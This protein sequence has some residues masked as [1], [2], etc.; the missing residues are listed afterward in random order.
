MA[1]SPGSQVSSSPTLVSYPQNDRIIQD[2][3]ECIADLKSDFED[4]HQP[5]TDD[6]QQLQRFCAKLEYLLR[7]DMKDKYTILGK[8]KDYWD[9]ICDCLGSTKGINDGIKYVKTLGDYKT[10][11]GKGRAFLRFC[12]MHNRM[13]DSLQACIMNGKVTSDY[14]QPKSIWLNHDKSSSLISNLYDLTDLQFDLAPRGYDLDNAWPSFAKKTPGNQNWNPP[15]RAD[16]MSSLI[17]IPIQ[18]N[19]RGESFSEL[20]D[21]ENSLRQEYG[22]QIEALEQQKKSLQQ[23]VVHTKSEIEILQGQYADLKT[24]HE[25]LAVENKELQK[26]HDRMCLEVESK[27]KEMKMREEVHQREVKSLEE[28]LKK[29]E[30]AGLSLQEKIDRLETSH[31]GSH[32]S[33]R[34]QISDLEKSNADLQMQVRNLMSDLA[35]SIEGDTKKS[36]EIS[37]Q[38]AKIKT[39]ES[40]NQELLQRME[41]MIA[42]KDSEASARMDSVNQMQGLVGNLKEVEAEKLRLEAQL[43]EIMRENESRRSQIEVMEKEKVESEE[44]WQQ[45]VGELERKVREVA[46]NAEKERENNEQRTQEI[47]AELSDCVTKLSKAEERSQSLEKQKACA[48]AELCENKKCLEEKKKEITELSIQVVQMKKDQSVQMTE[49]HDKLKVQ[50]SKVQEKQEQLNETHTKISNLESS[51]EEK[52]SACSKLSEKMSHLLHEKENL[53]QSCSNLRTEL[54][55]ANEKNELVSNS[56]EE[57][58]KLVEEKLQVIED[59]DKTI[60]SMLHSVKWVL[61]EDGDSQLGQVPAVEGNSEFSLVLEKLCD[62]INSVKCKLNEVSMEKSRIHNDLTESKETL[63]NQSTEISKLQA[64]NQSIQHEVQT[65]LDAQGDLQKTMSEKDG[66]LLETK[67]RVVELEEKL[68][69]TEAQL[70]EA[71]AESEE[72]NAQNVKLQEAISIM[73]GEIAAMRE[74]SSKTESEL[75]QSCQTNNDNTEVRKSLEEKISQKEQALLSQSQQIGQLQEKVSSL[76]E[77]VLRHQEATQQWKDRSKAFTSE[78]EHLTKQYEELVQRNSELQKT[79]EHMQEEKNELE[80]K[81]KAVHTKL[82]DVERELSA[83]Q[84]EKK[85][86]CKDHKT[87]VAQMESERTDLKVELEEALSDLHTIGE[88]LKDTSSQLESVDS[89]KEKAESDKQELEQ[90]LSELQNQLS[91]V[92]RQKNEAQLSL[93]NVQDVSAGL[94]EEK[95]KLSEELERLQR[96]SSELSQQVETLKESGESQQSEVCRLETKL[97]EVESELEQKGSDWESEKHV[98]EEKILMLEKTLSESDSDRGSTLEKVKE[99]ENEISQKSKIV[100]KLE[101]SL[102]EA[103]ME[104]QGLMVSKEE[105]ETSQ[106]RLVSEIETLKQEITAL[107]FQLSSDQIEHEK[108]LQSY[109]SKEIDLK[110]YE[111]KLHEKDSLIQTLQE[112]LLT[113]KQVG[114]T[115]AANINKQIEDLSSQVSSLEKEK[116]V[117]AGELSQKAKD[118]QSKES[119]C[120]QLRAQEE[121]QKEELNS[122][123]E[124]KDREISQLKSDMK[125]L[126]KKIVQLTKE[127]DSLWQQTDRLTYEQKMQSTAKWMDEKSVTHCLGCKTE[128]TFMVRK[129]HC[130]LCGQVFCYNCSNNYVDSTYSSKKSRACNLCY[131][132]YTKSDALSTSMISRLQEEEGPESEEEEEQTSPKVLSLPV[133]AAVPENSSLQTSSVSENHTLSTET[134]GQP[135]VSNPPQHTSTPIK[136]PGRGQ[137][138]P[139]LETPS[140]ENVEAEEVVVPGQVAANISISVVG[141]NET[142]EV[143]RVKKGS[144]G[145]G[146]EG[147]TK[148]EIFHLVSD[149][150]IARSQSASS[151]DFQYQ[152]PNPNVT[153][154]IVIKAA[155]L[156][157]GE[158]NNS[159]EFW[160]K[161]GKSHAIPVVIDKQNTVLCWEFTSHPKDV[162]FSVTYVEFDRPDPT[163]TH[164]LVPPCKCDSHKQA[165]RGEL[166]AKQTGVYSLLFDNTYSRITSKKINYSLWTRHLGS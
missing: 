117:L 157:K 103:M 127:K 138:T 54:K 48:D 96:E 9:Y 38:E 50:E 98:M 123:E 68:R 101:Q 6:N 33:L 80:D 95:S 110:S 92:E 137:S 16:S 87:L 113:L 65:T 22:D 126:K 55:H 118:L 161:P 76:E 2:I 94:E 93:R 37:N 163:L 86:L 125:Q 53:E 3:S 104:N 40:K 1:S 77:Q 83:M 15:S 64:E 122:I 21:V 58:Q 128:F 155:E 160:I 36:E 119:L 79:V 67:E 156:E 59:K 116:E 166:T 11:V 41:N 23:S 72:F 121:K 13:A 4:N 165:V 39:L 148:D 142:D 129:H 150:E 162:I 111:E 120:S 158:V 132:K 14:F 34:T 45:A 152:D 91:E 47:R 56:K 81:K 17:S 151:D 100:E 63:K 140:R 52:T 82:F 84:E 114:E 20:F 85:K 146:T 88:Q 102:E 30:E 71:T 62:H 60:E 19:R 32:D 139:N 46:D 164:S 78:H 99:L 136:D 27:E 26:S 57:N 149:E 10:S 18:E 70:Q 108:S 61:S 49:L 42:S 134:L 112:E 24:Q 154:G 147:L 25:T 66:V 28:D 145:E 75:Q 131:Q 12:L 97:A 133:P 74:K 106:G 73:K 144:V 69:K 135:V 153:T 115:E 35:N 90:Q 107:N 31:Q 143:K 105:G 44:K 141:Q 8:K 130:R 43:G 51:L 124:S 89:E 159:S 109:A 29:R 7:A 5:L